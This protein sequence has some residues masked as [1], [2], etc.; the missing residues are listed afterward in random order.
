MI[1]LDYPIQDIHGNLHPQAVVVVNNMNYSSTVSSSSYR[2]F[3]TTNGLSEPEN[4]ENKSI[5]INFNASLWTSAAA[6]HAK[7][8]PM[9]LS[10]VSGNGWFNL[11][12]AQAAEGLTNQLALCEDHLLTVVLPTLQVAAE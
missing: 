6:F 11:S 9:M 2:Q 8:H 4:S 1:T 5:A 12:L 3:D 10:D 7:K